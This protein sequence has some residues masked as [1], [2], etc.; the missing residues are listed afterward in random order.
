[1]SK[2]LLTIRLAGRD[3]TITPPT[4]FNAA[5]TAVPHATNTAILAVS[6]GERLWLTQLLVH[7]P[8][9]ATVSFY[10]GSRLFSTQS[11]PATTYTKINIPAMGLIGALGEDL[12]VYQSSGGSINLSHIA[13]YDLFIFES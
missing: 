4:Q 7:L 5:T 2:Q 6:A 9:A 10:L 8:I 12:I 3:F 1:M 13:V 11:I